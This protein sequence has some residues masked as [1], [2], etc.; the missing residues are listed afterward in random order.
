MII[1]RHHA[2]TFGL[3]A[4]ALLS[5]ATLPTLFAQSAAE[6][7]DFE[8][9][10]Q[11]HILERERWFYRQRAYP[12]DRIPPGA[13]IRAFRQ[14]Q[15]MKERL[16][17]KRPRAT[18][19]PAWSPIGP[20]PNGMWDGSSSGRITALAVDPTDSQ[21]VWAGAADGGVWKTTS[22]GALW[23][24][25][26]DS[27]P[28]LSTGSIAIDPS[29]TDT[30]YIG[31]G[32]VNFNSDGYGGAGILKTT[33]GGATWVNYPGPFGDAGIA[34][35]AVNPANTQNDLAASW[36]GIFSSSNG[37]MTWANVLNSTSIGT[38]IVFNPN[39]DI[40][41]AG[42]GYAFGDPTNG[43]YGSTNGGQT[44]QLVSGTGAHV[45]PTS[46]SVGRVTIA[47]APS[48][49]STVLASIAPVVGDY[50]GPGTG[51]FVTNDNGASWA[52]MPQPA[53]G[54]DWY[55][56]TLAI[57]PSNPSVI[58]AGGYFG[59]NGSTVVGMQSSVDGGQTWLPF[60]T[61]IHP[62]QHAVAF[63]GDGSIVYI[64][65][66]GGVRSTADYSNPQATWAELSGTLNITQ[67][68]PGL[69][70]NP[71]NI[72]FAVG[73]TQDN[74]TLLYN[75]ALL[76]TYV[77]CGD[78][79]ATAVDPS[80]AM[81]IYVT[82][83]GGAVSESIDGGKTFA[84]VQVPVGSEGAPFPT[85]LAID[86]LAPSNLYFT[87]NQRIYQSQNSGSSW[88]PVTPDI[89]ASKGP[90][91]AIAVAPS[92]SN[93]VYAGTYGGLLKATSNALAGTGSNWIDRSAGLPV[94][95]ITAIAVDLSDPQTVYVTLS[96]FGSGHIF[97]SPS[98]G[99]GWSDISGNLPDA[100]VNDL[101]LDPDLDGTIYVATDTGVFVSENYG[102]S[103]S[104]IGTGLPNSVITSV[105]F[106]AAS[107][108]L[109]AATHGRGVWD[110]SLPLPPLALA[111]G[112]I[113]NAASYGITPSNANP[114][115]TVAPGSIAAVFGTSMTS[116]NEA[117]AGAVPLPDELGGAT[118]S[119]D[120]FNTPQFFASRNQLNVQIPWELPVGA[121]NATLIQGTGSATA[122]VQ[123]VPYLP[124]IFTADG[125]GS[126]QGIV[127]HSSSGSLAAPSG[128]YGS[129]SP[130][131][132]GE[133]LVIYATGLGPVSPPAST[134]AASSTDPPSETTTSPS[135]S[136][137]GVPAVVTFSGL[138]PGL[139]GL[140]QVN[141]IVP[142]NAPSGN[143]VPLAL[144]IGNV[145]ANPVTISIAIPV[146]QEPSGG[147]PLGTADALAVPFPVEITGSL[148][149]NQGSYFAVSVERTTNVQF[150]LTGTN[151]FEGWLF[152]LNQDLSWMSYIH[153]TVGNPGTLNATLAPGT[154]IFEVGW[155]NDSAPGS[156]ELL[157][158]AAP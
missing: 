137:G 10:D 138:T 7:A 146:I 135:V 156:Y 118:L 136:V 29:D 130:A 155:D 53:F 21:V 115:A 67:F 128:V 59:P 30:V 51:L 44:W 133:N 68:Y 95:S 98:G 153:V 116:V 147:F 42:I 63:A 145:T 152:L 131:S 15:Q 110:L 8:R 84:V 58:V 13:R 46:A 90:P 96:G 112:G 102:V 55:R 57:S 27:Q 91:S 33:D 24:P 122:V 123:V 3:A 50:P 37:G 49:P 11:D 125:S 119:I 69:S 2:G 20:Q 36:G 56:N 157:V 4:A 143:A 111:T 22:G 141:F 80:N 93:T 129:S 5:C 43:I 89:T 142:D 9:G 65:N 113:L 83:G 12:F 18:T 47:L 114:T 32:E 74:G 158:D 66:D 106:H 62:D 40:V 73:G 126:G 77:A 70:L 75:G 26:T 120:G 144:T 140:N 23:L 107:R 97:T 88:Q 35:I 86:P 121:E 19:P 39:G 54:P 85:Y 87:G 154:W 103:W 48:N 148:V 100:P 92:D 14:R 71:S 1:R 132:K 151:G 25:M 60:S 99:A 124:G 127:V 94:R 41:W 17:G 134:G 117:S 61:G 81:N 31:T 28:T 109:R 82:C 139:V 38:S 105:R 52:A 6:K 45:L 76:W 149:P 64:G 79:G 101:A 16:L 104:P 34:A 108:T 150:Q 72:D 78:G